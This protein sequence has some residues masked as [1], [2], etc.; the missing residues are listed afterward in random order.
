MRLG[1]ID[2]PSSIASVRN[3]PAT[4]LR[5]AA[6]HRR[7]YRLSVIWFSSREHLPIRASIATSFGHASSRGLS[8]LDRLPL[9]L[10]CDVVLRLDMHSVFKLRQASF[11]ARQIVDALKEYRM[12]VSH[13]L[14]LLCALLRTRLAVAVSLSDFY[15]A[16]CTESC[17]LCDEFSGFISLPTWTRCCLGCLQK[18]PETQVRS[19]AGVRKRFRFTKAEVGSLQP[20]RTLPGIYTMD[21]SAHKSRVTAVSLHQAMLLSGQQAQEQGQTQSAADCERARKYNFM[22][23]CALPYYDKRTGQVQ[24]GARDK[25]YSRAGFL[26]HFRWCEHAQLLWRLS[27]DGT[28]RPAELPE[29]A[30]RGGYFS[31]R[32]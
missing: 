9:E 4:L 14:N 32:E 25:V 17:A 16:L 7:D 18:A 8:V 2:L 27:E 28:R 11:R 10:L 23:S 29:A 1:D 12:V 13:G 6:Y 21:E 20:F 26:R 19:L 22:G 15:S 5:V 3:R 31:P 30:R 24:H